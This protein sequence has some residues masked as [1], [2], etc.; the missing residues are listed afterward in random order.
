[1]TLTTLI[2]KIKQETTLRFSSIHEKKGSKAYLPKLERCHLRI[3]G[4]TIQIKVE[5][6]SHQTPSPNTIPMCLVTIVEKGHI[7]PNCKSK[8]QETTKT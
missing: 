3:A 8:A 2:G 7:V 4:T 6:I 1:M 5:E